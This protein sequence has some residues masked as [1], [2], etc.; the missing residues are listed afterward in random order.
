MQRTIALCRPQQL[1]PVFLGSG[2]SVIRHSAFTETELPEPPSFFTFPV[3]ALH[4]ANDLVEAPLEVPVP[5]SVSN[6]APAGVAGDMA[7]TTDE[8]TPR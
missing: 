5:V 6:T 4:S 2:Q 7:K 8:F 3:G 1:L